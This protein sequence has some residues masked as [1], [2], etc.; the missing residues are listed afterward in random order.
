M[1]ILLLL[2]LCQSALP[3]C[4]MVFLRSPWENVKA[5]AEKSNS[6]SFDLVGTPLPPSKLGCLLLQKAF[7]TTTSPTNIPTTTNI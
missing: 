4:I 7:L 6:Q 2:L 5:Q 3:P 1:L